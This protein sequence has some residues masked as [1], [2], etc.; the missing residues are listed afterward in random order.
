MSETEVKRVASFGGLYDTPQPI[1][2]I[3]L[4]QPSTFHTTFELNDIYVAY[5]WNREF[6]K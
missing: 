5:A 6:V 4:D 2:F 1:N 3:D